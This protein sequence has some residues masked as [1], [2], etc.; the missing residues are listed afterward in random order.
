M[1]FLFYGVARSLLEGP[2]LPIPAV[3][4]TS[5]QPVANNK[6]ARVGN[7]LLADAILRLD[8][9]QSVTAELTCQGA[10]VGTNVRLAGGYR[11]L[12]S[13]DKRCFALDL[14]GQLADTPLRWTQTSDG[15][16]LW[17]GLRWDDGKQNAEQS[18]TRI[19]LRRVRKNLAADDDGFAPQPGEAAAVLQA[20][21]WSPFGGLPMLLGGLDKHFDFGPPRVMKLQNNRVLAMVGRWNE[22]V[23]KQ[24]LTVT[25][26]PGAKPVDPPDLSKIPDRL[27][28]HVVVVLDEAQHTP[29]R[30]EYRGAGDPLS[31]AGLADDVLLTTESRAP[32]LRIDFVSV[33]F[34]V[35]LAKQ[36]FEF[37]PPE[38][39]PWRDETDAYLRAFAQPRAAIVQRLTPA[40]SQE[41]TMP[42]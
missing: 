41:P 21:L 24:L 7:S 4:P 15:R 29:R 37:R 5:P 30:I 35:A 6:A 16:L 9:R 1:A 19:D 34:D 39:A 33:G 3:V 18:L 38:S 31:A 26:L 22:A 20:E 42:R 12:G 23:L 2:K 40:L 25:P 28:Q 32:L 27:P 10:L 11:Q 14:T 13:G 8:R 36:Q 17:T